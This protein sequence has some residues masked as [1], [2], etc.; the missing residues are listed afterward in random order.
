MGEGGKERSTNRNSQIITPR[1]LGNLP[2]I[3]KAR[4]HDNSLIAIL[5]IIIKDSL[6][7]CNTRIVLRAVRLA[8]A[9][10]VPI[11]DAADEGR[12]Q[13]G[14]GLGGR[15]SLYFA[16][17]QCQIAVYAVI[18][19][20]DACGLDSFPGRGDL[21]Q[22]AGFVDADVFVELRVSS[23]CVLLVD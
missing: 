19:L 12:D 1:Q 15:D 4:T 22:D 3:P 11:Q 17:H 5:L 7:T 2:N 10:L 13:E 9:G 21:D 23:A 18:A 20:Q 6:H 8:R 14:A 16:E